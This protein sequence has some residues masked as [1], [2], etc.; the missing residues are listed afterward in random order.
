VVVSRI[1]AGAFAGLVL[2]VAAACG[3]GG[4]T[5]NTTTAPGQTARTTVTR[6][7][8]ANAECIEPVTTGEQI[9]VSEHRFPAEIRV[10][11]GETVTWNNTDDLNHTVSFRGGPN[12]GIMLIGQSI[13]ARFDGPGTY[14]Y[15]CQFHTPGMD[16][17]VIVE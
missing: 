2:V 1:A 13:T 12:C 8:Q 11:V 4:G 7:P 5:T 15:V 9:D 10:A 16:G 6:P 17:K 3:G 14:E